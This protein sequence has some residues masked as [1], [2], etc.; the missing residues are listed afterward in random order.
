MAAVIFQSREALVA[1]A[2]ITSASCLLT[3]GTALVALLARTSLVADGLTL[4]DVGDLI[5]GYSQE[6]TKG[7]WDRVQINNR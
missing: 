2:V 3:A 5:Q 6:D 7:I 1:H 4:I